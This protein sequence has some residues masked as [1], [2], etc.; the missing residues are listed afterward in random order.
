MTVFTYICTSINFDVLCI[1]ELNESR[2]DDNQTVFEHLTLEF[3]KPDKI[4]YCTV[5]NDLSE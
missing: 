5:A 1:Q 2:S 3:L 4:R